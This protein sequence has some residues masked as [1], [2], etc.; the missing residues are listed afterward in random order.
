MVG[1]EKENFSIDAVITWVDGSDPEHAKKLHAYLASLGGVRPRAAN[2][3]RFHDSGE[4]DYCVTSL[5]RFAPWLRTIYIVTDNQMPAIVERLKGT[6]YE[7]RVVIVDH[8][9]IFAGFEQYLPT[10]NSSSILAVLWRIPGLAERFI[11]LNDDF[12]LIQPVKPEDFFQGNRVVLRGNWRSFT[13][14]GMRKRIQRWLR[15]LFNRDVPEAQRAG[16]LAG[17]EL[18]AR[19]VGFNKKYFQI[20][21]NPHAWRVSTFK[22]FFDENPN[23]LEF[24]VK[25]RLRSTEQFIVEGLSAHLELKSNNA[26]IDNKLKTL[27]LKP[28]DQAFIRIKRKVEEADKDDKTAFVCVQS[29]EKAPEQIQKFVF[30]WLDKRVN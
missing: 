11:F 26:V 24:S 9:T 22:R 6:E 8:K 30:D 16:Y 20:P 18:S 10:F 5:L 27:Q 2:P 21:H 7:G 12:A 15:K 23:L 13:D 29:V 28:A 3:V 4:L 14:D 19:A 25:F 17:Q 1:A